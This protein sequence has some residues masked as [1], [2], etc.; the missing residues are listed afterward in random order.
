[1]RIFQEKEKKTTC[2]ALWDKYFMVKYNYHQSRSPEYLKTR[3]Y[4]TTGI[5]EIDNQILNEEIVTQMSIDSMFE[6]HRTRNITIKLI[7]YDDSAEIYNIIHEHL[8]RWIEHLRFAVNIDPAIVKDLIDLDR[9]AG[10][11]YPSAVNVF[12]ENERSAIESNGIGDLDAFNFFSLI[13]KR[14]EKS[15]NPFFS[16]LNEKPTVTVKERDSFERVL[17]EYGERLGTWRSDNGK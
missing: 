4:F 6:L 12:T 14:S 7:N 5:P 10:I 13:D 9:F 2:N 11:I 15:V 16:P 1:M 8:L 3:G 17:S